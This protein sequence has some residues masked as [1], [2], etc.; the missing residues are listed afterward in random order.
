M[1]TVENRVKRILKDCLGVEFFEISNEDRLN[2]GNLLADSLDVLEIVMD[3]ED[4]FDIG[5]S[6][7][8]LDELN[9]INITVKQLI[10]LVES[11]YN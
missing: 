8:E 7:E 1:D 9:G 11:K 5:I 2:G 4:E 10:D 3:I 6:E